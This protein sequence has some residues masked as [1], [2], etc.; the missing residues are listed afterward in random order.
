[1][2]IGLKRLLKN[3][4]SF[5]VVEEMEPAKFQMTLINQ[6]IIKTYTSGIFLEIKSPGDSR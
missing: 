4:G 2:V 5:L 6:P 3:F 1:M